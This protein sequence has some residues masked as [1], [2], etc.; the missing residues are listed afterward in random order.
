MMDV[1]M[2]GNHNSSYHNPSAVTNP[3]MGINVYNT[4][5]TQ[6]N[7]HHFQYNYGNGLQVAPNSENG[8]D[9]ANNQNNQATTYAHPHLYSPTAAEYGITTTQNTAS[10]SPSN[11]EAYY[12]NDNSSQSQQ[13]YGQTPG[14]DPATHIINSENGLS[15]TNLDCVYGQNAGYLTQGEIIDDPLIQGQSW[16]GHQHLP[17]HV[18]PTLENS[19]QISLDPLGLRQQQQQ[20]HSTQQQLHSPGNNQVRLISPES[21]SNGSTGQSGN[22]SSSVPTYKWMQLK[23]N[24]PKPQIPKIPATLHDYQPLDIARGIMTGQ[25]NNPLLLVGNTNIISNNNSGRTNFTN[26]QLTE[27]EKEFHFNRYLTRARRIEIANTLQLNETQEYNRTFKKDLF[28]YKSESIK[29]QICL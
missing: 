9:F 17:H 19:S 20:Q 14:P 21:N 16:H 24:V 22:Q 27:L 7:H 15:Y 8:Y 26:K 11:T 3:D 4:Y 2:Y 23:R 6:T 13:Y 12:E 1:G 29:T 28:T 25:Q 10:N 18:Y 5:F